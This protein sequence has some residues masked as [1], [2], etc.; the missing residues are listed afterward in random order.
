MSIDGV[1]YTMHQNRTLANNSKIFI[2][3]I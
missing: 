2:I 3:Y 1:P